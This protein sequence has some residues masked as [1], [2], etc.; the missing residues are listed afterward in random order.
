MET[1]ASAVALLA[2]EARDLMGEPKD[3]RLPFA[4][5]ERR[6][7]PWTSLLA[8]KHFRARFRELT[9]ARSWS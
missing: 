5:M 4:P 7:V 2:T 3:W 6:I 9:D 8:K 1:T